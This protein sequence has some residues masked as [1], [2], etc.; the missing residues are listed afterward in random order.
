[1]I[2][3]DRI[4]KRFCPKCESEHYDDEW[5]PYCAKC[6]NGIHKDQALTNERD[7]FLE[8][9]GPSIDFAIRSTKKH[10]ETTETILKQLRNKL[11]N[12]TS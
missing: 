9:I 10:P 2:V 6:I 8:E 1:M 11:F 4:V 5:E 7:R 12:L 3:I